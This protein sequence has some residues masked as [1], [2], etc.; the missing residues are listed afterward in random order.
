MH[1]RHYCTLKFISACMND[2]NARQWKKYGEFKHDRVSLYLIYVSVQYWPG[3]LECLI[4]HRIL[5][6]NNK[7]FPGTRSHRAHSTGINKCCTI[8]LRP[9]AQCD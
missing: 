6:I 1:Y 3:V 4:H 8:R 5:C 9:P 7:P 2:D